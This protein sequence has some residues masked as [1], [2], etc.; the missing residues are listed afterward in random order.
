MNELAYCGLLCTQCEIYK[1]T[2]SNNDERKKEV[3][4]M[5]SSDDYPISSD[6]VICYGCS[7][8]D[9]DVFKFCRECEIRV[10]GMEKGIDNCGMCEQYSCE[11]LIR[12]FEGDPSN[13]Q[14]LDAIN[15]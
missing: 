5:Y 10:C 11:K 1:A 9:G 8:N 13:K 15:K 14:R 6:D 4:E 3:A 2:I 12:P 7:G